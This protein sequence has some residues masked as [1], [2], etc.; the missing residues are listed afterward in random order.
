MG[1]DAAPT[2]RTGAASH[3][4]V[5]ALRPGTQPN[6]SLCRCSGLRLRGW[7]TDTACCRAALATRAGERLG[8]VAVW[9]AVRYGRRRCCADCGQGLCVQRRWRA[10]GPGASTRLGGLRTPLRRRPV[11]ENSRLER[12]D[13][14]DI[15]FGRRAAQPEQA[16]RMWPEPGHRAR[17]PEPVRR[18]ILCLH[19]GRASGRFRSACQRFGNAGASRGHSLPLLRRDGHR[20]R[21]IWN[22]VQS[23]DAPHVLHRDGPHAER[24]PVRHGIYPPPAGASGNTSPWGNPALPVDSEHRDRHRLLLHAVSGQDGCSPVAG[25]GKHARQTASSALSPGCCH[26]GSVPEGGD[27]VPV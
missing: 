8:G 26:Y 2:A 4:R 21:L 14:A 23:P 25:R 5:A 18:S 17:T 13:A 11:S 10:I 24:R 27:A 1:C 22:G 9:S 6:A 12:R 3:L 20:H 15:S 16:G 7:G 19:K